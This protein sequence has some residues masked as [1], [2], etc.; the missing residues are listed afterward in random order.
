MGLLPA[1]LEGVRPDSN[2]RRYLTLGAAV[3]AENE[4]LWAVAADEAASAF[5]QAQR[6]SP[7]LFL[8][9][10]ESTSPPLPPLRPAGGGGH[11]APDPPAAVYN[12]RSLRSET[13]RHLGASRFIRSSRRSAKLGESPTGTGVPWV[14]FKHSLEIGDGA[15]QIAACPA[16]PR[17]GQI[18]RPISAQPDSTVEVHKGIAMP[19][20]LLQRLSTPQKGRRISGI[21]REGAGI[22][23]ECRGRIVV[24]ILQVFALPVCSRDHALAR[25]PIR[26]MTPRESCLEVEIGR[27]LAT[28]V[29]PNVPQFGR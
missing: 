17:A 1:W 29:E 6:S 16:R 24:R 22:C 18:A 13:A 7:K 9:T 26:D 19:A 12:Q 25:L 14:L 4:N 23:T 3:V 8:E 28:L 2:R 20:E 10:A 27:H 11:G 21:E 5:V 15:C